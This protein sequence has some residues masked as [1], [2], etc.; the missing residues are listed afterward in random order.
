MLRGQSIWAPS[1]SRELMFPRKKL[2]PCSY[3]SGLRLHSLIPWDTIPRRIPAHWSRYQ[4]S[5]FFIVCHL[6]SADHPLNHSIFLQFCKFSRHSWVHYHIY[7][8]NVLSSAGHVSIMS[9]NC[10]YYA[11]GKSHRLCHSIVPI[12]TRH[13][14]TD[15]TFTCEET[16]VQSG[17]IVCPIADS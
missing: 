5:Y 17:L 11:A 12:P 9:A 13:S 16:E 8:D 15:F 14:L 2:L 6:I 10:M 3:S 1:L 4:H 7:S